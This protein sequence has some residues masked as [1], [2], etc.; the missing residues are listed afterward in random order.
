MASP[1]DPNALL[2]TLQGLL[3]RGT[4]SPLPHPTDSPAALVHAI[5]TALGFRL[6]PSQ[7]FHPH[8]TP[9]PNDDQ[10]EDVDDNQSEITAVDPDPTDDAPT[11]NALGQDW[12]TRGEDSYTFEYRH[13]QSAMV[14]RVRVGRMGGRVQVDAMA[15]DG[16]PHN[17]SL[18]LADLVQPASF[19]IPSPATASS[20]DSSD[21]G[22]AAKKLG[23]KSLTDVET[24][25]ERY[26][27]DIV[28]KL[29]PGLDI[30]GHTQPPSNSRQPPNPPGSSNPAATR[31]TYPSLLD[32]PPL[33][34]GINPA[35]IG[36]RD[37]DPF[38]GL[39]PGAGFNPGS[40]GGGMLVDFNHPLFA[41][42]RQGEGGGL[43]GGLG[44]D[45][46]T[47]PGG[48]VQPPGARWDPVG[49]ASGGIGPRPTPG[50]F[51]GGVGGGRSDRWGDELAPPGEFG[52]DLGQG[53]LGGRGSGQNG[54]PGGFGG[55]F[56]GGLGGLGGRGGRGG[57]GGGGFGG[58]GGGGGFGGG[59]YM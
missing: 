38:S 36:H 37:L 20:A 40:D 5:H 42:R 4:T 58:L 32:D 29:L 39:R 30:P 56:G 57:G 11:P 52:P 2:N 55:G 14:F 54:G 3:P 41:G 50:G 34:S 46:I 47:G 9:G 59:M 18:V 43:G 13:A 35:S 23:F 19:P 6:V 25:A 48:S 12:N 24:F 49:P 27:R 51:G 17:L 33:R 26:D 7:T 16:E 22:D 10:E 21:G 8:P 15:E 53:Q 1:L 44:G 31:P 45:D 28:S